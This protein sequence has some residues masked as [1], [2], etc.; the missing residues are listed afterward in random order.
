MTL[1]HRQNNNTESTVITSP[2]SRSS[3][4][5]TY[6]LVLVPLTIGKGYVNTVQELIKKYICSL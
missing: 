1:S 6:L 5:L 4:R 2:E 3:T